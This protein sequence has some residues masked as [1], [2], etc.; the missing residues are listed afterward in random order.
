MVYR[1]LN[2]FQ[3]SSVKDDQFGKSNFNWKVGKSNYQILRTGC[4]P[5]IK[6][7]C[8][9]KEEENLNISD[10]V[11]RGIKVVNLGEWGICYTVGTCYWSWQL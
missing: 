1:S 9:K 3:Y 2:Y 6:Y 11:M 10:T 5:Y 7:H 4:Y 8:S